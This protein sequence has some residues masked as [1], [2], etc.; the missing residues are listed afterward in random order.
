[1][2][3][4]ERVTIAKLRPGPGT[5]MRKRSVADLVPPLLATVDEGDQTAASGRAPSASGYGGGGRTETTDL[6]AR[7]RMR[8]QA[9]DRRRWQI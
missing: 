4:S 2:L 9:A 1:V 6:V 8:G 3:L 7:R 5:W